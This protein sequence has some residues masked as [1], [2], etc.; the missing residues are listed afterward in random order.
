[1]FIKI[2]MLSR[3]FLLMLTLALTLASPPCFVLDTPSV[4]PT[5]LCPTLNWIPR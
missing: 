1:L 4:K 5:F 2:A 3:F